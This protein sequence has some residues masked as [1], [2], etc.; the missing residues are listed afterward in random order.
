MKR[1]VLFPNALRLIGH[2]PRRS[3]LLATLFIWPLVT[4]AGAQDEKSVSMTPT[5]IPRVVDILSDV[6]GRPA[7]AGLGDRFTLTVENLPRVLEEAGGCK[8][9]VLF[10]GGMPVEDSPPERCDPDNGHV[11]FFLERSQRSQRTWSALL[12]SPTAFEIPVRVTVGSSKDRSY[13]TLIQPG[14]KEFR[15]LVVHQLEFVA[16]LLILFTSLTIVILLCR[17]TGLL[18]QPGSLPTQQRP[19]SIA[20]FQLAF[21]SILVAEAYLFVWLLSNSLDTITESVLA[22]VGIGSATALGGAII[23][24]EFERG[25]L[26]P[27]RS[28]GFLSDLLSD[29]SGICIQRFQVFTWTLILGVIFCASVYK[30][31]EMPQFSPTLLAL[32]GISSGTYLA[33]KVPE[34]KLEIRRS[35]EGPSE[36]P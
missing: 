14:G 6:P 4:P 22:L 33:F 35:S 30:T 2:A 9:I 24:G 16:F 17:R 3:F 18:R 34:K 1:L 32:M 29:S 26:P 21:W 23:D 5:A 31:L 15:L 19:F 27:R 28:C 10:I 36:E 12:G 11:G 20:R 25:S 13:P 7:A 8:Q